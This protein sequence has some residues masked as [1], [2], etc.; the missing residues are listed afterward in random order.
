MIIP[1]CAFSTNDA[2]STAWATQT[3]TVDLWSAAPTFQTTGDR[4]SFAT[5][6]L[7]GTGSHLIVLLYVSGCGSELLDGLY[8]ECSPRSRQLRHGEAGQ[9][10]EH[11]LDAHGH[12][13]PGVTGAS[14]TFTLTAETLN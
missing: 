1:G 8:A 7:T 9:R 10:D 5:D 4:A 11:L 13:R 6:L 2:T 14:K 12:D 3:I